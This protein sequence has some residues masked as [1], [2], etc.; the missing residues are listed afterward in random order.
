MTEQAERTDQEQAEKQ[1]VYITGADTGAGLL[2]TEALV[3]RGY[4]VL[5]ATTNGSVGAKAIRAIGGIPVYGELTSARAIMTDIAINQAS[6]IVHLAPISLNTT[7]HNFAEDWHNFPLV[8]SAQ[9]IARASQEAPSV[10]RMI[11]FSFANVYGDTGDTSADESAEVAHDTAWQQDA[12]RAEKNLLAYENAVV[13]RAGYIFGANSADTLQ[14]AQDLKAGRRFPPSD[15]VNPWLHEDDLVEALLTLL[16]VESAGGV[17]NAVALHA[18]PNEFVDAFGDTLG[19]GLPNKGAPF[20]LFGATETTQSQL[21]A[22]TTRVT[23]DKLSDLGWQPS[24]TSLA[25]G[26]DRTTLIW[27]AQEAPP[28]TE[29]TSDGTEIVSA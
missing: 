9:A 19:V 1:A 16:D 4:S 7:P 3:R 14:M 11:A 18:S 24:Y 22:Q 20:S 6:V 26:F 21:L 25:R 15:A 10:Q 5:G 2:L 27:R 23:S 8:T 29:P 17:Y 13:V 28:E 12:T